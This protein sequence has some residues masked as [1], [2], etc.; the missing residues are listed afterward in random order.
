LP[1]VPEDQSVEARFVQQQSTSMIARNCDGFWKTNRIRRVMRRESEKRIGV[2]I[3]TSD[4]RQA[5]PEIHREF[6]INQDVMG[7]LNRI[8]A[9][10]NPFKQGTDTNEEQT[11]ETIRAKQ[12]GH[13]LQMEE[14]IYGRQLQQNPF[15]M[16]REQGTFREVSVDWHRFIQFPSSYKVQNVSPDIKR[17]IKQEQDSRKFERWQQMR[18]IDVGRAIKEDVWSPSP[19]LWQATRGIGYH[20]QRPAPD[21]SR[22]ADGRWQEFVVHVAS[23]SITRRGH[24]RCDAEDRVARGH[25]RSVSQG[26]DPMCDLKR[27]S[28]AAVRRTDRVRDSRIGRVT[29]VCGF[30]QR[31][32]VEP[33]VGASHHRR[34]PFRITVDEEVLPQGVAVT[35]VDQS[36]DAGGVFDSNVAATARA[37]VHVDHGHG[38]QRGTHDP[39]VHRATQHPVQ[40]DHVRRRSGD[41]A[42]YHQRQ[43]GPVSRRGSHRHLLLQDQGDTIIHR[44]DRGRGVLQRG[45]RD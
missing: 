44:R 1:E 29:V 17:R 8:Y 37:S 7:T 26:W 18:Q 24:H 42:A 22:D 21:R 36:A 31:E 12:S 15:A 5:Y 11:R 39:R 32:D 34:V 10:E 23:S 9:N 33:A 28:S 45:G 25:G 2:P 6:A 4:W 38:A 14:S 13:S 41:V 40:R 16:R 20:R 27:W 3:G 30:R 35:R 19:V 43:V